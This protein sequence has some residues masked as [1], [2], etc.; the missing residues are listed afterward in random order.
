[1]T[2]KELFDYMKEGTEIQNEEALAVLDDIMATIKKNYPTYYKKYEHKLEEVYRK[3]HM[4]PEEAKEYV[5]GMDNKD[6]SKGEH[7]TLEQVKN[8]MAPRSEYNHLDPVC[9]YVAMNMMYSDYY[10]P[11]RSVETYANM[12][13]SF[14]DDKD[15][16][17][18]K[19]QRYMHAM[20]S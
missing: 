5:A 20:R 8:Y 17:A 13:K 16:P 2:I 6:G 9:F 3:H 10:T 1:M 12:A 15:A 7:W 19:L 4:D 18:D 14:L 11:T